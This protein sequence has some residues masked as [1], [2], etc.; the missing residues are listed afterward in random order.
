MSITT[1]LIPPKIRQYFDHNLLSIPVAKFCD[2]SE[3][4]WKIYIY[5]R[6]KL[7]Q[8]TCHNK[9]TVS[10][11]LKLEEE[12][13]RLYGRVVEKEREYKEKTGQDYQRPF[14]FFTDT[15]RYHKGLFGRLRFKS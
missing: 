10:N 12:F 2:D 1:T 5:I 8:K 9:N 11:Y 15:S 7:S 6:D 3:R 14:D 4:I 13:M